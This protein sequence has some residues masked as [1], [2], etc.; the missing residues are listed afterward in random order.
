MRQWNTFF[1]FLCA[2]LCWAGHR[3]DI[4]TVLHGTVLPGQ[5]CKHGTV[6]EQREVEAEGRRQLGK[7][8]NHNRPHLLDCTADYK[9]LWTSAASK[10]MSAVEWELSAAGRNWGNWVAGS[11]AVSMCAWEGCAWAWEGGTWGKCWFLICNFEDVQGSNLRESCFS[12]ILEIFFEISPLDLDHEVFQ[13]HFSFA[14][15]ILR[16][17]HFT[18]HSERESISDFTLFLEKILWTFYFSFDNVN[19]VQ[20]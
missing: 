19:Y 7:Y 4:G 11:R 18:F 15:L 20:S 5:Y 16:H 14:I 9:W 2:I 1:V 10:E 12:R 8:Q 3:A 13:F 6:Q 17:F